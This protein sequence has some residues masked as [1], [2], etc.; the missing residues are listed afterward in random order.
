MTAPAEDRRS[1]TRSP[2]QGPAPA[3]LLISPLRGAMDDSVV[4]EEKS[5][6]SL[7]LVLL[8]WSPSCLSSKEWLLFPRVAHSF[9]GRLRIRV[10]LLHDG[11]HF[12]RSPDEAASSLAVGPD[13]YDPFITIRAP[14]RAPA[15]I[16]EIFAARMT[17]KLR[18]GCY[19]ADTKPTLGFTASR[20]R[21][22]ASAASAFASSLGRH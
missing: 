8:G 1:N 7:A 22:S 18:S 16:G 11:P 5:F 17:A 19:W 15:P 12:T 14:G 2:G 4:L 13:V 21:V 10:L 6:V 9:R 20:A 3:N